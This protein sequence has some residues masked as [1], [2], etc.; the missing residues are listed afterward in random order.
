MST[1]LL[2]PLA[3][4][5]ALIVLIHL[6]LA[7]GVLL[8]VGRDRKRPAPG[9]RPPVSVVVA[10]KDEEGTLPA[11]LDS[12]AAQTM[13]G[14]QLVLVDDRSVD[15]TGAI[16][17]EF[18]ARHPAWVRVL[19]LRS[20]PP[21]RNPKQAALEHGYRAAEGQ[22]LAFTDADCVVP[23]AWLAGLLGYFE[24]PRVGIVFGQLSLPFTGGF[25]ARFQAFD[26]P[27]IHQWNSGMAGLGMGGSCFGNSLAA[28][29][30]VIEEV[31]G[32]LGLGDTLTEDAALVSAAVKRSWKVKVATRRD[33]LIVT[34]PQSS[35]QAFLNQHLRWNSGAFYH[36]D[37]GTRWPYRFIVL[38]LAAS[39]AAIP[40]CPLWPPLAM[41]P[42]ASFIAVGTMGF[43]A[44]IVGRP[45]RSSYLLRLVPYTLFFMGFYT[46][47]TVLTMLKLTPEWKGRKIGAGASPPPAHPV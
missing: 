36:Q 30:R 26:Q 31:G 21:I 16:M 6:A 17:E 27:L 32:F 40:F 18:R 37:P 5:S 19:H 29:R 23:P 14:F 22:V 24:D 47:A 33:T 41:L 39:V 35:W 3:V 34:R 13:H 9:P 12:L 38:F 20:D 2:W 44:G 11:L 42:A 7:V 1:A 8:N 10:A 25:L 46:L 15:R 43:L 45:A 4:P 28:R